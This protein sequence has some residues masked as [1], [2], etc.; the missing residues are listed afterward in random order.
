MDVDEN[1]GSKFQAEALEAKMRDTRHCERYLRE[2]L[3][4]SQSR[5]VNRRAL[6]TSI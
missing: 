2:T 5:R 1:V 4:T 6:H 3:V